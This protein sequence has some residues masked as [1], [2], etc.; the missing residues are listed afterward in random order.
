MSLLLPSSLADARYLAEL[1]EAWRELE[2]GARLTNGSPPGLPGY[3]RAVLAAHNR[4]LAQGHDGAAAVWMRLFGEL[5]DIVEGIASP[6]L[7]VT[8]GRKGTPHWKANLIAITARALIK[9]EEAGESPAEAMRKVLPL[10]QKQEPTANRE[11][12]RNWRS[13]F[14]RANCRHA[15]AVVRRFQAPLPDGMEGRP[16]REQAD[17]LLLQ[18]R[19]ARAL[20]RLGN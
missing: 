1:E 19:E 2:T 4:D 12:V 16:A 9:L 18:M 3:M 15:P 7:T 14:S 6:T 5:R 13:E 8:A 11:M 17:Y 20:K 10:V